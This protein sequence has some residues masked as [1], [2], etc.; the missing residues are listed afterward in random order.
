VSGTEPDIE[1]VLTPD[2]F[3]PHRYAGAAEDFNPI[4]LDADSARAVGLPG[5]ILHGL[6]T[7][8]LA[9]RVFLEQMGGDP[10]A[11]RRISVQ[12]RGVGLVEQQIRIRG[13]V[14]RGAAGDGSRSGQAPADG[15]VAVEFEAD[16]EG[17]RLIGSGVA[18]FTVSDPGSA[19]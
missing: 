11:L 5:A 2:R 14:R 1:V 10:R 4:H 8:G 19:A 15:Q 3:F 9:A 6:S 7:M 13:Q 18:E 16:Q 17:R 12:F